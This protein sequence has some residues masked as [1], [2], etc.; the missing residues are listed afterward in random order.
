MRKLIFKL[1]QQPKTVLLSSAAN[2]R[3]TYRRESS[4]FLLEKVHT[5]CHHAIS[6]KSARVI[7]STIMRKQLLPHDMTEVG[8]E[9]HI[10][11]LLI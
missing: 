8:K 6:F 10:L 1:D 7:C 2:S 9:S 4:G 11:G 3:E 5:Q